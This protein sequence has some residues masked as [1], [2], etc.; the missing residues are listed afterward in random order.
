MQRVSLGLLEAIITIQDEWRCAPV[1]FGE[2][3]VM[4]RGARL[5]HKWSA[6]N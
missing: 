5:K 4:I 1:D 2:Q 3:C 6:D